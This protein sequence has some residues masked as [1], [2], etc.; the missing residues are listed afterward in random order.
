MSQ[1]RGDCNNVLPV[2]VYKAATGD[3]DMDNVSP[4]DTT[5]WKIRISESVTPVQHAPRRV[6]ADLRQS[7]QKLDINAKVVEPTDWVSS[8]AVV[9]KKEGTLSIC[10]DPR[11][12]NMATRREHY[13]LP[14]TIEDIATRLS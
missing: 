12:L 7:F 13:H 4:S 6:P 14:P 2:H 11:D 3:L 8:L 1:S 9:P 5:I 10:F